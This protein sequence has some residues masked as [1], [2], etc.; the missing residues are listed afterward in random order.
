ML[1]KRTISI[2]LMEYDPR[3]DSPE[4]KVLTGAGFHV[5]CQLR[6]TEYDIDCADY[7]DAV[8]NYYAAVIEHCWCLLL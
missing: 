7:H 6:Q 3:T 2:P 1:T 8:T 4:E 5:F